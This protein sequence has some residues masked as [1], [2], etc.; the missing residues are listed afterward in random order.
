MLSANADI[1]LFKID[2]LFITIEICYVLSLIFT[3]H[4]VRENSVVPK[5]LPQDFL[6]GCQ[7]CCC[8]LWVLYQCRMPVLFFYH[9]L[10][11]NYL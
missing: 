5:V 4:S 2:N 7:V 11:S 3:T 6:E 10:L 8:H 9:V 1:T